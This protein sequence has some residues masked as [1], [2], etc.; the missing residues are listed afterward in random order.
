MKWSFAHLLFALSP[1]LAAEPLREGDIV[2][3]GSP[4][5]QGR[6]IM[7]ATDSPHSH[8]GVVFVENG[9]EMVLEAVQPVGVVDLADFK[10]RAKPGTFMACR[11]KA[12]LSPENLR[13]AR[14]WA[15]AQIGKDYDPRFLWGDDRLYCSELVWKIYHHAGVEL[16]KPRR[17]QDYRL[18]DPAVQKLVNERFGSTAN[19]PKNEKVVAPSDLAASPLLEKIPSP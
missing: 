19:L 13:L 3:S 5:G 7:N 17:F 16:C 10:A 4:A 6:A 8:C 18:D 9:K 14:S 15:E 2:F 1:L 11:L 12:P